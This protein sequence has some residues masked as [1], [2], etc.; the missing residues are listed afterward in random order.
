MDKG[1]SDGLLSLLEWMIL[2]VDRMSKVK[3]PLVDKREAKKKREGIDDAYD[4]F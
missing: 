4:Q 2:F 3:V 1:K